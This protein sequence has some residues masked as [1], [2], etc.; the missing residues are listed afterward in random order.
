MFGIQAIDDKQPIVGITCDS[1]RIRDGYVFVC[2]SGEKDSGYRYVREAEARGAVAI[3]ADRV[4]DSKL[5]V[6]LYK[7]PRRKMAE[8]ARK[9]YSYPDK[10]MY[11][12]GVTGTNGKTT[13]THLLR[14]IFEKNEEKTAL[15]G[16]NGCY[17]NHFQTDESFTTS[18]T[19]EAPEL[20]SILKNMNELGAQNAVMEVS[21]HSLAMDRVYGMKFDMAVFT[22]LSHDH[23]DFH[24]NIE[25]YFMAKENLF[26]VAK[27]CVINIDDKYGQYF[28][29]M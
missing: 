2:I 10:K 11:V 19:P 24:K 29:E 18:T 14:D 26:R 9:I 25:N 16:T 17:L 7:N 4:I 3:I 15:I 8:C 22:N 27:K 1:R 13:V 28:F 20:F 6:V 12:L 23:L 5:P 21:S